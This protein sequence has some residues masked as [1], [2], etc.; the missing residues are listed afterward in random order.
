MRQMSTSPPSRPTLREAQKARTR[1]ALVDA[2][3]HVFEEKGYVDTTVDEIVQRAG[4]SRPTFY[5]Y[6]SGKADALEAVV[7]KLQLRSEFQQL[8]ELVQGMGEPTVEALEQWFD[9]YVEFYEQ[10]RHIHATIHQAQVVD[11]DF[12]AAMLR[13]LQAFVDLWGSLGFID[14]PDDEDLRLGAL[15]MF[16]LGEQFLYLWLVQ[17]IDVERTKAARA[18]AKALHATLRP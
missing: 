2:A 12:A 8:L 14:D 18:L 7:Q 13:N 1:D 4:A 6:F 10:H 17:G 11:P 9:Q 15:M 5:A 3:W 16:A